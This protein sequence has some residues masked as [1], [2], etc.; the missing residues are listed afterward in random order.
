MLFKAH[1][2]KFAKKGGQKK[3]S[4]DNKEENIEL[5]KQ[6]AKKCG[7]RPLHTPQ[8]RAERLHLRVCSV[9][10]LH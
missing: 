9:P 5:S 7:L 4:L 2:M 3:E 6:R 1:L 8:G 10:A